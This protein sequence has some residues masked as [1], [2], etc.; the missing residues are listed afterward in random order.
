[1]LY[2]I[3][4]VALLAALLAIP[5]TLRFDVSTRPGTQNDVEL[6]WAFGLL[7]TKLDATEFRQRTAEKK[8]PR[9]P[10]ARASGDWGSVTRLLQRA[11]RQR[12]VRILSRVCR[13]MRS[14]KIRIVM[15]IGL[16]DPADTGRLWG[17][18]GP[19]EPFLN[20][21]NDLAITLRPDFANARVEAS[22]SGTL[23]VMPLNLIAVIAASLL[24][25]AT[26]RDL[27]ALRPTNT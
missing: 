19:L 1:M 20:R 4:A 5:V 2:I 14:R 11:P 10:T 9:A 25:P 18:L 27:R 15:V 21:Y 23:S 16:G 22:S 17:Y 26:W 12:I 7:R 13:T 8:K 3:S 6:L 24:S